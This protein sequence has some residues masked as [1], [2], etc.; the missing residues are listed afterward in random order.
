MVILVYLALFLQQHF[1]LI[2][3]ITI[4]KCNVGKTV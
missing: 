3:P 1:D 2:K 4:F